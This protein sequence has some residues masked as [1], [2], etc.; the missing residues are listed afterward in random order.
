MKII[1]YLLHLKRK[2]ST[3]F[4]LFFSARRPRKKSSQQYARVP[5]VMAQFVPKIAKLSHIM[6]TPPNTEMT[7]A[8]GLRPLLWLLFLLISVQRNC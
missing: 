6:G 7:R 5:H 3:S 1:Q 8:Y 2:F 4:C